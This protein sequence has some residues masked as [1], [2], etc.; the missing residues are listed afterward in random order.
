M[1]TRIA[2]VT[3]AADTREAA[4]G[5]P[6]DSANSKRSTRHLQTPSPL[7]E[8]TA[9]ARHH[10]GRNPLFNRLAAAVVF[11][12]PVFATCGGRQPAGGGAC[13]RTPFPVTCQLCWSESQE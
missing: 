8:R 5:T 13:G 3:G 9:G 2:F 12:N 4:I 1:T 6:N 11:T 10:T 7:P